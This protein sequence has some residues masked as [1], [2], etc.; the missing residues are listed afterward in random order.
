VSESDSEYAD[1]IE[2]FR[3]LRTLDTESMGY[4]RQRDAIIERC[5]PLADHV[6]RR[7]SNR[8]EPFEDL[9]QVARLGLIN[10]VNRFDVDK[11]A[12]F[13]SFAVPTIMGEV[14]RHFRDHGWAVKVPRRLKELSQ[15]LKAA[16]EQLS[17]QLGHAPT[18]TEIAHHLGVDREE[19]IQAL[20]AS[21]AY[22]TRSSD[23]PVIDGDG[24]AVS[25]GFGS[26]DAALDKVL[27][28]ETVRPLLA[29]LPERE[30]N[31]LRL[32][33]F[34]NMSQTHIAQRF[35]IS[36]MHVSRLLARSLSTLREAAQQAERPPHST[37][38]RRASTTSN[39]GSRAR[40]LS[41]PAA[42]SASLPTVH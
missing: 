31:V 11:G 14:R 21:S 2:M 1:V 32:R 30:R 16:R 37:R 3:R 15:Q 27:D 12:E 19:V 41:P 28:I 18:A 25:D 35:G 5:L 24:R 8:G 9:A 10:A 13:T 38:T 42:A 29:A 36:Q 7:F 20:L 40:K 4:R 17:Q 39:A 6:A 23:A 26:L 33:F 22:S 34:E